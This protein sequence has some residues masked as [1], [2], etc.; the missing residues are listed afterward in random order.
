MSDRNHESLADKYVRLAKFEALL[1]SEMGRSEDDEQRFLVLFELGT[2]MRGQ[3][4][5]DR[6]IVKTELRLDFAQNLPGRL[7]Q[8]NPDELI[9]LGQRLADVSDRDVFDP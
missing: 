8:S 2:L 4:V 9:G 6:E 5:F 1:G 3:G 7:V